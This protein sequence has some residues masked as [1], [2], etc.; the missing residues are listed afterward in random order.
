M[1]RWNQF[2]PVKIDKTLVKDFKKCLMVSGYNLR[3]HI[4]DFGDEGRKIGFTGYCQYTVA[5]E[6]PLKVIKVI[7]LLGRF[8]FFAGIGYGTPRGMGQVESIIP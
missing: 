6:A 4:L 3:T 8:G 7:H 2:S 1:D 5:D